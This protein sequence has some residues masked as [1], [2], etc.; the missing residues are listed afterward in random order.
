VIEGQFESAEGAESVGF[1]H[2][3]FGFVVQ[4][5]DDAAG[6]QFLSPEIVED[7]FTMLTQG[8]G[9]LLHGFDAGP[10]DLTTPFIEEFSGP[11]G[12]AVIPE[13]LKDF[14]QKVS[15][16]GLEVVTKQITKPKVLF[17]SP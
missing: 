11:G 17:F 2:R 6:E 7:Q 1:S 4:T 8:A 14:L 15:A 5:L 10:H 3:D 9:D 13:L 16:N 12:G